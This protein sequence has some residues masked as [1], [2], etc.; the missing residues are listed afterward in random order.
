MTSK[1]SPKLKPSILTA[2]I[3]F[4]VVLSVLIAFAA[5]AQQGDTGQS[6]TKS[7]AASATGIPAQGML[8]TPLLRAANSQPVSAARLRGEKAA[9]APNSGDS[10]FLAPVLYGSGGDRYVAVTW[11]SIAAADVNGDGKLDLVV[12]NTGGNGSQDGSVGVLLGN[13]DGTFQPAV[14][15]DS[16]GGL[17]AA[18]AVAD[19][20]GDGKLDVITA[21][22]FPGTVGVLLGNGDGTFQ[23]PLTYDFG[24]VSVAVADVN[25]DGKPD[26]L[27]ANFYGSVG[28]MLG[29]GDGTFQPPV[30]YTGNPFWD[31]V[32]AV[33]VAD[34]NGDGKPDLLVA[35]GST[36]EFRNG[37]VFVLL[38][39][40]DGTF[41]APMGYL[42]G[43][44]AWSIA[45]A[46][47]NGDGKPDLVVGNI[48]DSVAAVLL[49]N[50]D[51][52][53]QPALTYNSGGQYANSVAVADVNGDGKPDLVVAAEGT[54]IGP[55]PNGALSV[56]LGNGDGTFLAPLI[57]N[58]TGFL[59]MALVLADV[60]G[61]GRADILSTTGV[62]S[63]P[64]SSVG[65]WLN[66]TGPHTPATTTLSSSENP[67]RINQ[68]VTYT[69]SVAGERGVA[70]SGTVTFQDGAVTIATVALSGNQAAYTTS[71]TAKA[72]GFRSITASY[73]GD[74]HNSPS[75]S[76]TLT[77]D[78]ASL[79][80]PSTTALTTSGSP[81]FI[82]QPV[83]LT[84]TVTC[85]DGTAPNGELVTFY[86]ETRTLGSVALAGG[87]ASYTTS[88]LTLGTHS[89]K[90][91]YSGDA[92]FGPSSGT[93]TQVINGYVTSIT[94]ISS[95]NPS[96]YGQNVTWTAN[97][98][99]SG[100]VPPTGQVKFAWDGY[101][102]GTP[103]VNGG[104]VATL[105][106]SNLNAD[107][108]PLTAAYLGDANNARSTSAVLI[109]LVKQTTSAA[110]LSSSP[111]P[112]TQGQGVTFTATIKSPTV[113][114]TGPVTFTA[115]KTVIGTAQLSGGKARFTTS[116]LT[117]GSTKVTAT[118]QGDSNIA[119][120]S[121]S[122]TQT[123]QP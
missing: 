45:V 21:N 93:A 121:A 98:T 76:A 20:N 123:V 66:N 95:L 44:Y 110:T 74:L 47:V 10:L 80:V 6:S 62:L 23:P 19:V 104:G 41:G 54:T 75:T 8:S 25:G 48:L 115:G 15:S 63:P 109:Q 118:Y 38:N 51:G 67:V 83:T 33:A 58:S 99:T 11:A 27:V 5:P 116:T 69:A 102:I 89:I 40:G 103:T 73:S 92:T 85:K 43:G 17:T 29:N 60:N 37:S 100:P 61:D 30:I 42:S 84:A 79:P 106:R 101:S 96:F 120:S 111:N 81:S 53:F 49:G 24:A 107:S 36:P 31:D 72:A 65:V 94:L 78:V 3:L 52:T 57:Y 35:V 68:P 119:G 16:G 50:G 18:V 14:A 108:Y 59:P 91:T 1:H 4:I 2:S 117:V 39:N 22:A 88:S 32:N 26:L 64:P 55:S 82:G 114:P 70:L 46:D 113:T 90:A 9:S 12:T 28:V 86:E 87:L 34:V 13:G 105:T 71:Y 56:L 122:V 97:V 112:S 77:E 7:S